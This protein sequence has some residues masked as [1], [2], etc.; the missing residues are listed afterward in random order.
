MPSSN[1]T[2]RRFRLAAEIQERGSETDFPCDNY[3]T[4]GQSYI[5]MSSSRGVKY[6]F[7]T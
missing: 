7:C 5:K 3:V 2:K 1:S 4:L 6:A